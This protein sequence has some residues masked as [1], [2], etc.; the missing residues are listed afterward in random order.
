MSMEHLI[1]STGGSF[2]VRLEY[3]TIYYVSLLDNLRALLSVDEI[4]SEVFTPTQLNM[5]NYGTL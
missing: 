3:I 1:C 2:E 4:A 5:V